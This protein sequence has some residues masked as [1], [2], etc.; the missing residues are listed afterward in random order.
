MAELDWA[1]LELV[2]FC[3]VDFGLVDLGLVAQAQWLGGGLPGAD[4]TC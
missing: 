3:L 4:R 2:D 1:V